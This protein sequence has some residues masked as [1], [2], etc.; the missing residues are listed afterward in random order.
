MY[1]EPAISD[2]N[3][4]GLFSSRALQMLGYEVRDQVETQTAK[5]KLILQ[6]TWN[7]T[8]TGHAT[9]GYPRGNLMNY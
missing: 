6:K 8:L 4:R 5:D 1:S 7:G 2:H 3:L 9:G